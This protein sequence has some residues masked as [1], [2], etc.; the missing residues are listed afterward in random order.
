VEEKQNQNH[1]ARRAGIS[2][3]DE[4]TTQAGFCTPKSPTDLNNLWGLEEFAQGV[5]SAPL[6]SILHAWL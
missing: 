2:L 1:D 6:R 4:E 3:D 5:K